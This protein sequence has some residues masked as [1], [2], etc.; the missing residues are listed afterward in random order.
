MTTSQ[1]RTPQARS[2]AFSR[3]DDTFSRSVAFLEASEHIRKLLAG[4]PPPAITANLPDDMLRSALVLSVA[5][6]DAYFTDRF[7]EG[8]GPFLRAKIPS[9]DLIKLIETAGF[10]TKEAITAMVTMERPMRRVGTLLKE[11]LSGFTTTNLSRIDELYAKVGIKDFCSHVAAKAKKPTLTKTLQKAVLRRHEIAHS[12]DKNDHGKLQVIDFK[13]CKNLVQG[14]QTFVGAAEEILTKALPV[15]PPPQGKA[16]SPT[17]V[18]ATVAASQ[19]A[20]DLTN[21]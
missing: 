10:N 4:S 17:V 1:A 5:A 16:P 8:L 18:P 15:Q 12:G 6:M 9:S 21:P 11:H 20:Q 14:I 13:T 3:F 19:V 7:S 2:R